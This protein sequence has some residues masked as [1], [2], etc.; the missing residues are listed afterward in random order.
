MQTGRFFCWGGVAAEGF[1][2]YAFRMGM[3][4]PS[5][6]PGG[7]DVTVHGPRTKMRGLQAAKVDFRPWISSFSVCPALNSHQMAHV[8]LM[9]AVPPYRIVRTRQ[10]STYFLATISGCGAVWIDGAWRKCSPGQACMLPAH[11]LN[12]FEAPGRGHWEFVWVSYVRPEGQRLFSSATS[13]VMARF[14]AAPLVS[15]VE[16]LIHEC[17]GTPAPQ[18][19]EHWVEL[20][21]HYAMTFIRPTC[22]DSRLV[23]L[24][25]RVKGHLGEDWS[26]ARLAEVSGF[27]GEHLRRL[28]KRELGRSPMNQLT[29]LRMRLAAELLA[30]TDYKIESVSRQVGYQNPFVF[31]N[32]FTKWVGWRPSEYRKKQ[33][34]KKEGTR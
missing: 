24:W 13:P 8:G 14:N 17:A 23:E 34:M 16:G 31:S 20:I 10:S 4:M 3:G 18:A 5:E 11:A 30:G 22:H 25:E 1:H 29:H 12:A 2:P 15:A 21:Q 28:C 9:K 33:V 26:L 6:P 32:T 7:Q 19:V 27:S